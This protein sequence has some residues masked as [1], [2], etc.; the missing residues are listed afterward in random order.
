M[1][2]QFVSTLT[3]KG[4][5]TI[6]IAVRKH[7]KISTSDKVSFVIKP[8]GTVQL[9]QTRYPNI[10]SLVGMAGKLKRKMSFRKMRKIAYEERLKNKYGQ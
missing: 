7:M 3:T 4:Q 8:D 6:P 10:R 9:A 2:G 5:V 1:L